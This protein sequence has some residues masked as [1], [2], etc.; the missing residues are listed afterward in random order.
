MNNYNQHH[1]NLTGGSLKQSNITGS[2]CPPIKKNDYSSVINIA[3]VSDIVLHVV[4]I[5]TF[6]KDN[7]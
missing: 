1:K 6:N 7:G 5:L 3:F 2:F 4:S